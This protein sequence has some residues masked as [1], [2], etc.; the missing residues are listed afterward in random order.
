[1]T[2]IEAPELTGV[3]LQDHGT[4]LL[5]RS[6]RSLQNRQQPCRPRRCRLRKVIPLYRSPTTPGVFSGSGHKLTTIKKTKSVLP[7][8]RTRRTRSSSQS[9]RRTPKSSSQQPHIP[10]QQIRTLKSPPTTSPGRQHLHPKPS[11]SHK[12]GS[13][14]SKLRIQSCALTTRH[15]CTPKDRRPTTIR[16]EEYECECTADARRVATDAGGQ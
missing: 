6:E 5:P 2:R 12:T 16:M 10:L 11:K 3:Y 7:N 4:F 13:F 9:N 8:L 15:S 14:S 1:M